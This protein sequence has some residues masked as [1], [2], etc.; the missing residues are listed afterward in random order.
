MAGTLASALASSCAA[1]PFSRSFSAASFA[2]RSARSASAC[3]PAA[4]SP[5]SSFACA[6]LRRAS[7]PAVRFRAAPAGSHRPAGRHHRRRRTG[8]P[9]PR[10]RRGPAPSTPPPR[11]GAAPPAPRCRA[12]VLSAV[13][14]AAIDAFAFDLGAVPGHHVDPDQA[15]PRARHQRLHQQPLQPA[16]CAGSRTG[17]TSRDRGAARRRSPAR[18]RHRRWPSPPPATTGSPCNS[19]TRSAP[20]SSAGDTPVLPCPSAR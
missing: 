13:A 2:I 20:P 4:C 8:R 9:Q 14:F 7:L 1:R 15:L 3:W 19:S 10:R 18:P 16:P 17:R 6:A 11:L 12:R 5:A